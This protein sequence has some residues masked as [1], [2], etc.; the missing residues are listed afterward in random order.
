M[1]DHRRRT[2]L[3]RRQGREWCPEEA[4]PLEARREHSGEDRRRASPTAGL[5]DFTIHDETYKGYDVPPGVQVLL[6]TDE[7]T[8]SRELAWAKTYEKARVV[9]LQLGHDHFAYEDA[10]FQ[11]LL[12]N[13][14]RWTA[15]NCQLQVAGWWRIIS[16]ILRW[17]CSR[18]AFSDPSVKIATMTCPV[19]DAGD[20]ACRYLEWK[21]EVTT[22]VL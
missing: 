6:T 4:L 14:N 22:R 19:E 18:E 12:A 9:F 17:S 2:L 16:E 11:K 15:G 7:P 10:D 20:F 8:S 5:K 13:A 1:G 3:S 21:H